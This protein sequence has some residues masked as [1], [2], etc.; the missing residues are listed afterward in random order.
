MKRAYV[1]VLCVLIAVAGSLASIY[2]GPGIPSGSAAAKS[3][4][5]LDDIN[6]PLSDDVSELEFSLKITPVP[7]TPMPRTQLKAASV[8]IK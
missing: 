8:I 1:Y 4:L 7:E 3:L 6:L 5:S 2:L